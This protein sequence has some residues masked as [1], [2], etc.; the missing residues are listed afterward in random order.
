MFE[1]FIL[2]LSI[3]KRQRRP[4]FVR[5]SQMNEQGYRGI[6]QEEK[7]M[8]DFEV[9]YITQELHGARFRRLGE[10]KLSPSILVR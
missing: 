1:Y 8:K 3:L 7:N 6:L 9:G 2:K 10:E 5:K 4:H